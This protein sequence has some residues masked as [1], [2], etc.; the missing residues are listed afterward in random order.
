MKPSIGGVVVTLDQI[1]DLFLEGR[2]RLDP[3]DGVE[4]VQ[5]TDTLKCV[6]PINI[7]LEHCL[8]IFRQNWKTNNTPKFAKYSKMEVFEQRS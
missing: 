8:S 5:L 3:P 1:S 4:T 2:L 6:P 7:K